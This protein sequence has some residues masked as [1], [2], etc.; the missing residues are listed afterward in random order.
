MKTKVCLSRHSRLSIEDA[1]KIRCAASL[2]RQS[3]DMLD[4]ALA[5]LTEEELR[6]LIREEYPFLTAWGPDTSLRVFSWVSEI[7]KGVTRLE[8]K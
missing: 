5:C 1:D 2:F 3:L 4:T 8:R 7:M 6:G